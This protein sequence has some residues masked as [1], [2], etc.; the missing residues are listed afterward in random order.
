MN[1]VSVTALQSM[2]AQETD[3]VWLPCITISHADL[4]QDI[5]LVYNTEPVVR[6]AGTFLPYAFEIAIPAQTDEEVPQVQ[7]TVD[8]ADLDVNDKLRE[9]VGEPSVT[10]EVA[11]ASSPNTVEAG[12]FAMQ[13]ASINADVSTISGTLGFEADIFSQKVPAQSYLPTTSPGIFL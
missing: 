1:N 12:P 9:L 5:R 4:A 11:L 6:T 2:L 3:E 13:L 10:L 8:N 7:L